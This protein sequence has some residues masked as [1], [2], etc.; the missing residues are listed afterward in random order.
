MTK[1]ITEMTMIRKISPPCSSGQLFQALFSF[2]GV[3][4]E[5]SFNGRSSSLAM[6]CPL[7]LAKKSV[8]ADRI[9][10]RGFEVRSPFRSLIMQEEFRR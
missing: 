3:G 4:V 10:M 8:T 6:M 2:L 1:E 9:R 5:S 7:S